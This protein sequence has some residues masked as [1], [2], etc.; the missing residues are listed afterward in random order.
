MQLKYL[1]KHKIA[2]AIGLAASLCVAGCNKQPT[3]KPQEQQAPAQ[4]SDS[5]ATTSPQLPPGHPDV[6][7]D[8]QGPSRSQAGATGDERSGKAVEDRNAKFTHFRVGDSNVKSIFIDGKIVWV[9]TSSGVIRYNTQN[10]DFRLFDNRDGLLSRGI[11]NV[12]KIDGKITVGTYGG[13]LSIY[14]EASDKW[15]NYNVPNGLADAFVYKV[16]KASNGD[17]WI[18]TWSGANRIRGG[19]LKD[20]SSW[21]V[22]TVENTN[23]GLPNDWVYSLEEG[24]DG[25][26]WFATEGGVARFKDG[27]WQ[28]WNHEKGV[29]VDFAKVK[30]DPQ[31]GTD[32]ASFSEHHAR[33]AKEMGLV[34]V[35]GG[36]AYNPNYIVA[37]LVGKDGT[38]WCGTWGGGLAH[39]D[40]T[41]WHNYSMTDG[42]PGNHV[43]SLHQDP[44]GTI[45]VGTN[46][47]LASLDGSKFK[48][49]TT[50][51]GLFANAVFSMA[52]GPDNSQWI[53]SFGGVTHLMPNKGK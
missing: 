45:W 32:P 2:I 29:G 51:D 28:N 38:V 13:G 52:T 20:R 39:F 12:T 9:G 11:F 43:F 3:D 8:G 7:R 35:A 14:D 30:N 21:E 53:G 1:A 37:L 49:L 47:G 50:N 34:G 42:L 24:K 33:Q 23:G 18:A 4:N 16:L 46:N 25:I 31:F 27:K 48:V 22:Y 10:D 41:K 36:A 44:A 6:N 17:I 15:E 26:I 19:K 40:G 5:A